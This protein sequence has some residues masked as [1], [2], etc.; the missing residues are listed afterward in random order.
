M[1]TL[2]FLLFQFLSFSVQA[3][4]GEWE[5][6]PPPTT[7]EFIFKGFRENNSEIQTEGAAAIQ[8]DG[9]LRLTDENLDVTGTAFYGKPVRLLVHSNNL[10]HST[11]KEAEVCSFSTS[12]VFTFVPSN[13]SNG[14]GFGFTFTLS[15]TPTRPGAGSGQYFG[16][17][18]ETNDGNPMN[19]VF[20]VKFDTHATGNHIGLSF[21]SVTSDVQI[22]VAYTTDDD[23]KDGFEL[24]PIIVRLD[25]NGQNQV[26]NLIV[27]FAKLPIAPSTPSISHI[28][29][30][31]SEIVQEKMYVGFTAATGKNR[32]S[33]H[34]LMGWSFRSCRDGL[35]ADMLV[36][37]ELPLWQQLNMG[38]K[39]KAASVIVSTLVVLGVAAFF[40]RKRKTSNA[41]RRKNL[42]ALTA[43]KHYHYKEVKRFTNSFACV[44]GKGGF[45]TVYK[46]NLPDGR[47]VAVKVLKDSKSNGEDFINE[48][49]SMSQTSHVNIVSLVG[50]CYEGSKRMIV[51][52][53]LEN[54]SLDQFISTSASS[55][56]EWRRRLYEILLGVARGLEYLHY[57][58]KTRIVH[59]DIKPQNVLLDC[60]LCPK[61][62]D[63]GLAK[64]CEKKES[65]MSLLDTRGT[66]GYIAPEMISRV[67]GGVSHK[68]DVYSY[69]MLVLEMIGATDKDTVENTTSNT[70]SSVYFP[71]GIYNDLENEQESRLYGDDLTKEEEEITK[72]MILV[73]LWCIQSYPSNRPSMNRV[74]EM[75]EG[76]LDALEVPP[77]PVFQAPI[78]PLQEC[79]TLS[80]DVSVYIVK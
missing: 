61:V 49:A 56:A 43:L 6:P 5:T 47:N 3:Q 7:T 63:F 8:P 45:G 17:L 53:F 36:L 19:H 25:Y 32:S 40:I 31:L 15:P 80:G 22:P 14:G 12:F 42:K 71:D 35:T 79:S 50:F 59:F 57:G 69:G 9:L 29:P 20:A 1:V 13:S 70:T 66:I 76:S 60:N 34:Y 41:Q 65:I 55:V 48:V 37:Q 77:R 46:G 54:G 23:V 38:N 16:L 26:L 33:A 73:A 67:Y 18:N 68:S 10:N 62:S 28:V 11:T 30:K 27:S 24:E 2:L 4:S 44:V 51:Y 58:C 72:K 75:M 52:E 74:V 39:N 64:L 78:A 21:N